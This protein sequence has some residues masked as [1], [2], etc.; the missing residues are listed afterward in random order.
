MSHTNE[1]CHIQMSHVTYQWIMSHTNE[2]RHLQHFAK[3]FATLCNTLQRSTAP[4]T[5]LTASVGGSGVCATR[6]LRQ[7]CPA[8]LCNTLQH[9]AT[10]CNTLDTLQHSGHTATLWTHCNTLD[11]LQ[12]STTPHN[13]LQHTCNTLQR[14]ATLY[15]TLQ[16]HTHH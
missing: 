2:S 12:H 1:S 8:T 5:L 6:S 16:H 14:S 3:H 15:N 7:H 4:Y 11:T 10:H 9:S 13:T